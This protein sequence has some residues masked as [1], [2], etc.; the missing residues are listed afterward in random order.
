MARVGLILDGGTGDGQDT[1]GAADVAA[2]RLRTLGFDVERLSLRTMAIAPCVGCFRC[3]IETPGRC[4]LEDDGREVARRVVGSDLVVLLTP[5]R[6][7][8]YSS[9]LKKALDRLIPIISP[10]FRRIRGEVHHRRRY[11]RYPELVG[12]GVRA[13]ERPLPDEEDLFEALVL[14]N[15]INLRA[16]RQAACVV[17]RD[18]PKRSVR[19]TIGRALE[20]VA[21]R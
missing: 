1:R 14:R 3:W 7:G 12:V 16:P 17:D 20:Q 11:S 21:G 10:F 15:A 6:F 2:D 8:G 5:I 9:E 4:V 18:D 13:Q 19:A